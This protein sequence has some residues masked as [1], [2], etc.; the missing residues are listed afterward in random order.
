MEG[1]VVFLK[2]YI[3]RRYEWHGITANVMTPVCQYGSCSS[4]PPASLYL[5]G[6]R[7]LGAGWRDQPGHAQSAPSCTVH[8]VSIYT[9][10]TCHVSQYTP[11][12]LYRQG[13]MTMG[14]ERLVSTVT[15]EEEGDIDICSNSD[16]SDCARWGVVLVLSV[17]GDAG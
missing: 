11:L 13:A 4:P 9:P 16:L 6:G 5:A 8:S 3:H 17:R 10:V 12:S 2:N 7:V 1:N 15:E 14:S